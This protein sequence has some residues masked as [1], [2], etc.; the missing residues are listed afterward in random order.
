M[1]HRTSAAAL[2]AA[3]VI[4]R[5]FNIEVIPPEKLASGRIPNLQNNEACLAVIIDLTTNVFEISA[6][7]PELRYW[8]KHLFAGTASADQIANFF[9]RCLDAFEKI[10]RSLEERSVTLETP[11]EFGG[12][13]EKQKLS[14]AALEA[15]RGVFHYYSFKPKTGTIDAQLD[16]IEVTKMLEVS[17]AISRVEP[18]LDLLKTWNDRLRSGSATATGIKSCFRKL[19]IFLEYLPNYAER[20]EESKLLV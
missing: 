3:R 10:P 16:R 9:R 7:R 15:A 6:L 8:Q 4:L 12:R 5:N 19:G 13:P 2:H 14:R 1:A 18:A 17:L 11:I 20:E